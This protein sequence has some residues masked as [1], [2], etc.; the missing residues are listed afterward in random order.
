MYVH[1]Y[2]VVS[3]AIPDFPSL[4][5]VTCTANDKGK[6]GT[7]F[8]RIGR[9]KTFLNIF[10][11]DCTEK[12]VNLI[13]YYTS[14]VPCS[15]FEVEYRALARRWTRKYHHMNNVAMVKTPVIRKYIQM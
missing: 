9:R 1:N 8:P 15:P 3:K 5:L 10:M 6:T 11:I 14:S 13:S 2:I 12:R 7:N 4:V